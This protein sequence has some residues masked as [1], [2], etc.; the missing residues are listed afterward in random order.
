[1][2]DGTEHEK[3]LRGGLVFLPKTGSIYGKSPVFPLF[4]GKAGFFPSFLK[5]LSHF[6]N[7]C[8]LFVL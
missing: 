6:D 7:L 3:R 2:P 4:C 5:S 8:K 1:M